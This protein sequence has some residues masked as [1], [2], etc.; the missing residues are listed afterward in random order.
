[1]H[2][3]AAPAMPHWEERAVDTCQVGIVRGA[4]AELGP[5]GLWLEGYFLN[6][7]DGVAISH[8]DSFSSVSSGHLDPIVSAT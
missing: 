4:G 3:L 2:K 6:S 1:M 7:E 8:A 5:P